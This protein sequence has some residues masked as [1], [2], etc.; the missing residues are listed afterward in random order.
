MTTVEIVWLLVAGAAM[1]AINNLAGAAGVLGLVAFEFACGLPTTLANG[2]LR[3]A[4]VAIGL[5][6]WL[7]F[8]SRGVR[9][10]A[11]AWGLAA[12]T[13][14][15]A[16]LGVTLALRLP[17]D[18]YHV[19][20]LAVM[21][22]VLVQQMRNRTPGTA[23]RDGS[24]AGAFLALSLVGLHMGFVQVGVGL[25]AILVLTRYHSRDLVEVNTTKMALVLV[26]A[27]ISILEFTRN[28]A[29][30]WPP[31][32]VLAGAAGA[33]SFLASRWSVAKGHAAVRAVVL[34]ITLL[35]VTRSLWQIV[36]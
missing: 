11:R 29:L 1:G 4:A 13:V 20:L 25:I 14:P 8:H 12:C 5:F 22:A 34:A 36:A 19:Y 23:R 31:A 30:A 3:P 6:G 16:L 24:R 15:G 18:V 28:A 10:P 35:V 33:G 32:L 21:L 2:S 9:I 26:S 27:T 17:E 7:G